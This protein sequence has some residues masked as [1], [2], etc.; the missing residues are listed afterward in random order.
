[1]TRSAYTVLGWVV[2]Q[3]GSRVARRK[4]AQNRRKVAVAAGLAAVAV[5]GALAAKG[6]GDSDG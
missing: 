5:A 1:M 6:G 2:W 4:L 3:V